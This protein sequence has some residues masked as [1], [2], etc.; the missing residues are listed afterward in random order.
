M[1]I[2]IVV[3]GSLEMVRFM[4]ISNIPNG[5]VMTELYK[6]SDLWTSIYID[7]VDWQ[8]WKVIIY[9]R[10]GMVIV[11]LYNDQFVNK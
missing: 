5:M 9:I 11:R 6:W 4:C 2:T 1:I 8:Y 10:N 7:S 3:Q